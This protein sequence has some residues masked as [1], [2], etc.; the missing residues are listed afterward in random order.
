GR[1]AIFFGAWD[2][3]PLLDAVFGRISRA[4]LDRI[5]DGIVAT[6]RMLAREGVLLVKLWLHLPL[7][8]QKKRLKKLHADPPTRW[9]V[10]RQDWK[11]V[12]RADEYRAVSEQLIRRTSTG[13]AP[14][15][16]VEG[17]DRRYR[18]LTVARTLLEALGCRL[19][20]FST[21]PPPE[22]PR[23]LSLTPAA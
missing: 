2:Q 5:L 20:K 4:E 12:V 1:M 22:P 8:V 7:V 6:E 17:T 23:A 11:V 3:R 15:T 9:R 10:T 19:E 13:E 16:I 14:W 18:N 21:Q